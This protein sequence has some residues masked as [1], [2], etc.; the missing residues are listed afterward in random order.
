MP[1]A[2][3]NIRAS[4]REGR[5]DWY[6]IVTNAAKPKTAKIYIYDEIGYWGVTSADFAQALDALEDVSEIDLRLNSPGGEVFEGVAIYNTLKAHPA[7][8]NVTVDGWACS[9][10]SFIAMAGDTVAMGTGSQLMIHDASGICVGQAH[11]MRMLADQLD[12]ISDTIASFYARRAG[13]SV[14]SWR[15]AMRAETWYSAEEAVTAGL[16]DSVTEPEEGPDTD[17]PA[18]NAWD[19]S[20]FAYAGRDAAP[21]PILAPAAQAAPEVAAPAASAAPAPTAVGVAAVPD[22][23]QVDPQ[24]VDDEG[25]ATIFADMVA[26]LE[27]TDSSPWAHLVPLNP[28]SPAQG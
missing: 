13:G 18:K 21:G 2:R 9:A 11:D 10:A 17:A 22:I 26:D 23:P 24:T 28:T 14:S 19:L 5:R 16:A 3:A 7:T 12:Q 25:A 8:V 20:V 4:L 6:K 27:A 1:R 15:D